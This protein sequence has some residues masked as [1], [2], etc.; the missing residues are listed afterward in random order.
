MPNPIRLLLK[1]CLNE[2]ETV[3]AFFVILFNLRS[4]KK[5][6][7]ISAGAGKTQKTIAQA[8]T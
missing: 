2:A 7:K 4:I 8:R 3:G 6:D 1:I 5:E